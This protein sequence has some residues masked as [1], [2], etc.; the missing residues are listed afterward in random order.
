MKKLILVLMLIMMCFS[1]FALDKTDS[2]PE[3]AKNHFASFKDIK[4]IN[5]LQSMITF[6]K[7]FISWKHWRFW[8]SVVISIILWITFILV[9]G[10]VRTIF[11]EE[12]Q[13]KFVKKEGNFNIFMIIYSFIIAVFFTFSYQHVLNFFS[14]ESIYAVPKGQHWVIWT[15]WAGLVVLS[16][17]AVWSVIREFIVFKLAG[18]YTNVYQII[19]GLIGMIAIFFLT[20]ALTYLIVAA[21][22]ILGTVIAIIA[23]VSILVYIIKLSNE[24]S[25][26]YGKKLS[27]NEK[28]NEAVRKIDENQKRIN[29]QNRRDSERR[30]KMNRES[31]KNLRGW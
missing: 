13:D 6:M 11:S 31:L 19:H 21:G 30:E 24:P 17:A 28:Y 18:L 10:A 12:T 25:S 3:K 26:S 9:D 7:N 8:V 1:I 15:L 16:L 2:S 29:E 4:S 27:P 5:N 20:V 22:L 23:G 14:A